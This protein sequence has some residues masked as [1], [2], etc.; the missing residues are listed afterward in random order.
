M[1]ST[2]WTTTV[3]ILP[4]WNTDLNFLRIVTL[5]P[6]LAS[7]QRFI[8]FILKHNK[9][10][11]D[12]VG[13]GCW[14]SNPNITAWMKE[15]N[16]TDYAKLEEI[17]ITQIINIT[18]TNSFDYIVWE[19]VFNNGININKNTVVEVWLPYHPKQETYNVTKAGYRALISAPWYLDL[20]S[21]GADWHSYYNYEPLDF[22]GTAAQEAL[23]MGGEACLWAEFVDASNYVSRLF[24]RA[25]AVAERL[26]SAREVSRDKSG[27]R[28]VREENVRVRLH[29]YGYRYTDTDQ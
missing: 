8:F 15:H 6:S 28:S 3:I 12:E 25:S 11:G 21:Y 17:W 27:R 29:I 19:E 20:I 5:L 10:G 18:E 7:D 14:K 23:V 4:K 9:L 13:F 26:W 2:L 16:L 24:P 22:N 1:E